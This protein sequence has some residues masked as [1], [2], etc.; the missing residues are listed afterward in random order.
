MRLHRSRH[1]DVVSQARRP[2]RRAGTDANDTRH[3]KLHQ[4]LAAARVVHYLTATGWG[5]AGYET[6]TGGAVD[7]DVVLTSPD[8][9]EVEFQV[10][11]PDQ[12]GRV[13]RGRRLDGEYDA[14]VMRA[15]DNAAEQLRIPAHQPA[16]IALCAN[17]AW[18]LTDEPECIVG[19]IIGHTTQYGSVVTLERAGRGRT[20]PASCCSI[21]FAVSTLPSTAARCSRTRVRC[22]RSRPTGSRTDASA[23]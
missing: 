16:L 11:A 15:L 2:S 4:H 20:S 13:V 1:S 9:D 19:H 7:I 10:K 22:F 23:F 18:P 17:R 21:S 6:E 14:R 12:P 5:F 8:G 3:L